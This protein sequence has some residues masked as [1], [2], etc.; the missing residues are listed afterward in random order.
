MKSESLATATVT[1]KPRLPVLTQYHAVRSLNCDVFLCAFLCYIVQT[2]LSMYKKHSQLSSGKAFVSGSRGLRFKSP[3]GVA[4]GQ[5]LATTAT[6]LERTC[7]A[8]GEM[9]QR[10]V[11]QPRYTLR[12]NTASIMKDLI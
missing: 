12:R 5:R 8:Q 2:Y 7:V 6:F 1:C 10:W 3:T 9:M 4:N 11:P